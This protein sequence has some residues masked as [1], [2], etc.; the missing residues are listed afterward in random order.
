MENICRGKFLSKSDAA[1][2]TLTV[3]IILFIGFMLIR[4]PDSATRGVTDG[5]ELCVSTLIPSLFPFMFV[6]CFLLECGLLERSGRLF[7]AVTERIFGLP[8]CCAPV[9]AFS[10]F[11]GLPVGARLTEELYRRGMITKIQGQRMLFFCMNPGPAFVISGV[12]YKMLGSR[13]LGL[14]IYVSLIITSLL[15]GILSVPVWSDTEKV[16]RD[17][18]TEAK[19]DIASSVVKAV[20]QSSRS[21]FSICA[22]VILFS[23]LTELIRN[24]GFSQNT[25][26]F[27]FAV[28]EVT[29]GCRRCAGLYPAPVIAGI[30]G[31]GGFCA[32]MQVATPIMT[33]K[34][35][36]KYFISAR[37]LNAGISVLISLFILRYFPVA[38]ETAAFGNIPEKAGMAMSYP[39]CAG[40]MIMCFLLLLGDNFRIKKSEKNK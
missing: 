17:A 36:Y 35:E 39:I 3:G 34:L 31:F 4:Y 29:N 7:S 21:V 2:Y 37:I 26:N 33:L 9:I 5:I 15:I 20:S 27:L 6:S 11:A 10:M 13:E 32:H 40:V 22:W 38:V 16:K 19:P 30:I 23:G 18:V 24:L 1:I 25:E 12:G 8:G 28:T 14:I